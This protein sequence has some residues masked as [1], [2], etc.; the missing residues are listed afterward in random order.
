[1][2]DQKVEE[3]QEKVRTPDVEVELKEDDLTEEQK[4]EALENCLKGF[5]KESG[6]GIVSAVLAYERDNAC[7][8]QTNLVM[9]VELDDGRSFTMTLERKDAN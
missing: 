7:I 2:S 3:T 9:E 6:A 8:G 1:M 4:S 5:W